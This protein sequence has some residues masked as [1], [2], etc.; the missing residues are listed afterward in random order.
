MKASPIRPRPTT[1]MRHIGREAAAAG[2]TEAGGTGG[3]GVLQIANW[4][5]E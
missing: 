3:I 4:R 5:A 2:G 1:P